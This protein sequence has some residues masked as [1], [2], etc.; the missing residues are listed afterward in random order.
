MLEEKGRIKLR[1]LHMNKEVMIQA[2][3][4]FVVYLF[5][6]ILEPSRLYAVKPLI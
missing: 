5:N 4:S 6:M 2:L 3:I 1:S